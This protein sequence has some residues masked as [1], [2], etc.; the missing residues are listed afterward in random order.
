MSVRGFGEA[1]PG[2]RII[3]GAYGGENRKS[4]Q[5]LRRK[6]CYRHH[7]DTRIRMARPSIVT[8]EH[9]TVYQTAM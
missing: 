2:D 9:P 3:G 7:R 1:D 8:M 6:G 4:S 5:L